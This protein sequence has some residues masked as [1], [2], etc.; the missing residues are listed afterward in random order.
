VGD[1]V[2]LTSPSTLQ[3]IRTGALWNELQAWFDSGFLLG[4]GSPAGSDAEDAASRF[5]IVAGHAYSIL[6][7]R[8]VDANHLLRLR[9]PWGRFE[10]TGR[11]SDGDTTRW[12]RRMK[13][14]CGFV[15]KDDGSFWMCWEDFTQQF[16]DLYIC[17]FFAREQWVYH[18][19]ISGAWKGLSAGGNTQH[20]SVVHSP[21][22]AL[23]LR[24]PC[25]VVITL[26]QWDQRVE[27]KK[28]S[29][30]GGSSAKSPK[31]A[32]TD[33]MASPS[34]SS[35]DSSS[36]GETSDAAQ[37]DASSSNYAIGI[38]IYDNHGARVSRRR[39]GQ[40]VASNPSS[41]AFR[42]EV[43]AQF[44]LPLLEGDRAY[45][46]LIAT[47]QPGQERPYILQVYATQ[48]IGFEPMAASTA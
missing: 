35:T 41:Y 9:N 37:L 46:V 17:R 36:P 25:D 1:R 14:K 34:A 5:G 15:P 2:D 40:L 26:A 43:T 27:E 16:E 45:T 24:V 39:R 47:H 21:Q 3:S 10:W 12:T 7:V 32:S 22:Y 48:P 18:R 13:R 44:S 8:R 11:W 28:P 42:R 38:E 23:V 33:D 4:A 30:G 19:E 29:A 6:A 20:Y 31:T